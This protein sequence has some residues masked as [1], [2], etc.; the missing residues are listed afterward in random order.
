[1]STIIGKAEGWREEGE[2]G[3]FQKFAIALVVETSDPNE[4]ALTDLDNKNAVHLTLQVTEGQKVTEIAHLCCDLEGQEMTIA[5]PAITIGAPSFYACLAACGVG[6]AASAVIECWK[7]TNERQSF[8]D[9]LKSKGVS[10]T[11]NI[12]QCAIGCLAGALVP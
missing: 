11:S 3:K 6:A 4:S 8:V 1:M 10:V 12:V 9:C 7:R 5:T 2:D